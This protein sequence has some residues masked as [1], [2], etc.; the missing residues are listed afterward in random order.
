MTKIR[1]RDKEGNW[2]EIIDAPK[3][4]TGPEGPQGPPGPQGIPGSIGPQG[5][6]GEKGERGLAGPKGDPGPQGPSGIPGSLGLRGLK[7]DKGDPGPSPYDLWLA[8]GNKGSIGEYFNHL[9]GPRGRNAGGVGVGIA[10]GG[11]SGQVLAK[12][13]AMDYATHWV[14]ASAGGGIASNPPIGYHKI[15]NL[16]VDDA[17]ELIIEHDT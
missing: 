12:V 16:Y 9:K 14:D 10:P 15:T 17:G 4:D 5:K 2:Q 8:Q 1:I 3:G 11:T 13:N 7:G 6:Q